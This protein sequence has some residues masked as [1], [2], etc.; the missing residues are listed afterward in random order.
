MQISCIRGKLTEGFEKQFRQGNHLVEEELFQKVYLGP[1]V[2]YWNTASTQQWVGVGPRN[3]SH[4]D[5]LDLLVFV[6]SFDPPPP[7]GE[8]C[9]VGR[10]TPTCLLEK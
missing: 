3:W 2:P 4:V 5:L 8:G 10:K 1:D 9:A 7:D 6:F